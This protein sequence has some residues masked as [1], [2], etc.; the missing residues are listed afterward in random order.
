MQRRD[1]VTNLGL[2]LG[3]SLGLGALGLAESEAFA[4]DT[5]AKTP[6]AAKR[7]PMSAELKAVLTA[8]HDCVKTSSVCLAH[9][10]FQ[11]ANGDTSLG[12]CQKNVMNVM[13]VCEA[14]TKLAAYNNA[15]EAHLKAFAKVCA[16]FCD[17]CAKACE[18]HTSHH[19]ECKEC[20]D[21]CKACAKACEKYAA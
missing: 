16:G 7:R 11:L 6:G 9:C 17:D 2:G 10:Q 19:I 18:M 4:A 14:L 1:F 20:Y 13:A 3:A 21:S 15:N 5:A 12:D 8:A